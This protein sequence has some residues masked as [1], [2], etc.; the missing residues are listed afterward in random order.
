[1]RACSFASPG[2]RPLTIVALL[3]AG[4]SQGVVTPLPV[5]DGYGPAGGPGRSPTPAPSGTATPSPAPTSTSPPPPAPT[6]D[7]GDP[8]PTG[9]DAG[10]YDAGAGRGSE[11]GAPDDAGDPSALLS[12]CSGQVNQFRDQNDALPLTESPDLESYAAAAATADA[13]SGLRNGYFDETGGGGI[14]S[15]EDELDGARFDPGGTAAQTLEQGLL[16]DEQEQGN[17]AANLLD[18]QLSEVGCGFAQDLEGNWW[19]VIALR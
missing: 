15:T 13:H 17:A 12:V 6:D 4:C 2:W 18:T 7:G 19:V 8:G 1:M 5:A 10:V 16:D 3:L 9:F 14:A 11:A